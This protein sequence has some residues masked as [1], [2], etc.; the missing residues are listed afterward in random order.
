MEFRSLTCADCIFNR[1]SGCRRYPPVRQ[2]FFDPHQNREEHYMDFPQI[3]DSHPACGE[4]RTPTDDAR[5]SQQE[6][7]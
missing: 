2:S 3:Y 7:I 1:L 5:N 6:T 4:H